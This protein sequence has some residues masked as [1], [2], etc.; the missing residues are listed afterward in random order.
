VSVGHEQSKLIVVGSVQVLA[1]V[2]DSA[3]NRVRGSHPFEIDSHAIESSRPGAWRKRATF[4]PE[5]RDSNI[6]K[7]YRTLGLAPPKLDLSSP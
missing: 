3:G 6:P 7:R 2:S 1:V 4:A 5:N